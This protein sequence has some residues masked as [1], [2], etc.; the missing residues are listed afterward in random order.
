MGLYC[1]RWDFSTLFLIMVFLVGCGT[2]FRSRK[3]LPVIKPDVLVLK[4]KDH[5]S[6][7]RTFDGR[8]MLTMVSSEG[9]FTGAMSVSVKL[10]DSL[11]IKVEG[12]LG[13]DVMKGR[14]AG[15]RVLLYYPRENVAYEGS[16][17]AMQESGLLP[18]YMDYSDIILGVLG[19]L[20]P[21][22]AGLNSLNSYSTERRKYVFRFENGEDVW[23]EPKG[24][25]VTRWE[26]KD[27]NGEKLWIWEG[28]NYKKRGG[29][30]LPK[31]IQI[32]SYQPKEGVYLFYET[33]K[34]NR[35]M[36]NGWCT[37][38][39]PKGVEIVAL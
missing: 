23:V 11:F 8:G 31:R 38:R 5:A 36:K 33:V 21:D 12:P 6:R 26:K 18:L 30:R 20:V 27:G 16:A 15:G 13:I 9:G 28:K 35:P 3:P 7:L 17:Q 14:F 22:E 34:T 24:P 1:K 2:P 19:L 29:I 10:P 4:I 32:T 37:L 39:I 25:V